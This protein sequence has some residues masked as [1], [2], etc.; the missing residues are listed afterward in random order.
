MDTIEL[1]LCVNLGI[2]PF[3][4]FL[5]FL[6]PCFA[7]LFARLLDADWVGM[8]ANVPGRSQDEIVRI[9]IGFPS[10]PIGRDA[11][12]LQQTKAKAA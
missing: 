4:S 10:I 6:H 9:K 1:S 5:L 8:W 3:E 11:R 7:D 2:L 12:R